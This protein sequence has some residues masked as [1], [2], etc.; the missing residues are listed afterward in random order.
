M[1]QAFVDKTK[2]E[3]TVMEI[4]HNIFQIK[5]SLSKEKARL[6]RT[7]ILS[8]NCRVTDNLSLEWIA[9]DHGGDTDSFHASM[10]DEER[11]NRQLIHFEFADESDVDVSK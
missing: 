4:S 9:G 8:V 2:R 10:W 1:F 5:N 3:N 6:S 7:A 11:R